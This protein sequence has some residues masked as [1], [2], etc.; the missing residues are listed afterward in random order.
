MKLIYLGLHNIS[1]ER[2]EA[3]G[4]EHTRQTLPGPTSVVLEYNW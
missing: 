2:E 4:V 1:S 3:C